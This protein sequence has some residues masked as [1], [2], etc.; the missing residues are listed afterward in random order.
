MSG[1]GLLRGDEHLP[2]MPDEVVH[3]WCIDAA[4]LYIDGT[5][6]RG[7]HSRL[8]LQSLSVGGQ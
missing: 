3:A 6:G 5:F 1:S 8:L 7:G 4:G 2:V